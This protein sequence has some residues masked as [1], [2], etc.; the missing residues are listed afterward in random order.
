[1]IPTVKESLF[2]FPMFAV[3]LQVAIAVFVSAGETKASD[4]VQSVVFGRVPR[5][6]NVTVALRMSPKLISP[7]ASGVAVMSWIVALRTTFAVSLVGEDVQAKVVPV[8]VARASSWVT[9][10][11]TSV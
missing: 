4:A 3:Q 2:A 10:M 1:M 7:A 8:Y 11:L 5:S 6:T 9:V